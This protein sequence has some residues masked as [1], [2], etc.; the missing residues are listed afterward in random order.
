MPT[1]FSSGAGEFAARLRRFCLPSDAPAIANYQYLDKLLQLCISYSLEF[2]KRVGDI[3]HTTCTDEGTHDF[4]EFFPQ[5]A[6]HA[7]RSTGNL[8]SG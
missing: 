2:E 6:M 7:V 3:N 1:W 8:G 5:F 4:V